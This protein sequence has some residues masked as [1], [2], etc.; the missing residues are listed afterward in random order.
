MRQRHA[1]QIFCALSML[2][3]AKSSQIPHCRG[4]VS[5][6]DGA[7]AWGAERG[8]CGIRP[9]RGQAPG[10]KYLQAFGGRAGEGG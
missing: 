1:V 4:A 7:R 3:E 5:A 8:V 6:W 9:S 2:S 10:L